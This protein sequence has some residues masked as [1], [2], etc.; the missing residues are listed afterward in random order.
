MPILPAKL[1]HGPFS[2]EIARSVGVSYAQLRFW[3]K[4]GLI[5]QRERGIFQA[6]GDD[7]NE[8]EIFRS[9]LTRVGDPSVI[10]SLSALVYY[11]LTDEIPR[12]TWIMV[13]KVKRSKHTDLRLIRVANLQLEIGI[14]T[15][16]GFRI[17]SLER[18]LIEAIVKP[19]Y[20]GKI[21]GIQALKQALAEKKTTLNAVINMASQLGVLK[22]LLPVIE[23]LL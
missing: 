6:A 4:K 15:I 3:L 7:Y 19:R 10:C 5:E 8:E 16:S 22:R 12:Q 21:L 20:V 14:V 13:P 11:Q 1:S 17:T 2:I 18:T 23:V 9:A